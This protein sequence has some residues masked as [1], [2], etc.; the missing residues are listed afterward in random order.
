MTEEQ[1]E[2]EY[3]GAYAREIRMEWGAVDGTYKA[4]QRQ[5]K[6][7]VLLDRIETIIKHAKLLGNYETAMKHGVTV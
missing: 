5:Y 3:K 1:K 2:K 6:D 7:T 4:I